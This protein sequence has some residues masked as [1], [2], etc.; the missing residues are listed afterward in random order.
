MS[1]EDQRVNNWH[2]NLKLP[3]KFEVV[4]V[5]VEQKYKASRISFKTPISTAILNFEVVAVIVE[6]KW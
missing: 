1:L 5:I 6:H 4:A 2:V 3:H